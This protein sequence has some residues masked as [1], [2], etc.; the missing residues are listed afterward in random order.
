MSKNKFKFI[1]IIIINV[2]ATVI[3]YISLIYGK[4]ERNF[5]YEYL[6][7]LLASL[8]LILPKYFEDTDLIEFRSRINKISFIFII[9]NGCAIVLFIINSIIKYP[10]FFWWQNFK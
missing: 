1:I 2:V 5:G 4:F 6:G 10:Y 9:I 7:L 8:S 3:S